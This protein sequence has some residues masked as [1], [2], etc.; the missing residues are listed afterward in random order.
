MSDFK[1]GKF[2]VFDGDGFV[3]PEP[4]DIIKMP[5]SQEALDAVAQVR[6]S[7]QKTIGLRPEL[8]LCASAMLLAAAD[9]PDISERVKAL[10]KKIYGS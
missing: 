5:I 3:E 10:G 4:S 8:S 9:L 7:A 6:K 1:K 2:Y